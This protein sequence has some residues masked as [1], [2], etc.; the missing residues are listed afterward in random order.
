MP[1]KDRL[2][3]IVESRETRAGR[4]FDAFIYVTIVISLLDFSFETLPDLPPLAQSW[5]YAVEVVTVAIFTAEYLLRVYVADR[6]L[7]FMLSPFGIIDF[8]AVAPFYLSMG[9]DLRSLRVLRFL[10]LIRVLKIARYSK[11]LRLFG[12]AFQIARGE[13]VL[14]FAATLM[15]IY[16]SA[17][18]VY[19]FEHEAQPEKFS[20]VFTSLWW[21]VVTLTTVGYGDA[22][23]ITVGGRICTFFILMIGL[24]TIAVP[25]GIV[26]AALA[27]ARR[28]EREGAGKS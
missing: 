13:L 10:R 1:M 7:G 3:T 2:K 12:R 24:G 4:A 22:Y 27:E 20:S 6:K 17:I 28:K 15:L 23:P 19:Y 5:L 11:A 9:F 25:S 18:L 16:L 26:A 21:A 8:L 14:F